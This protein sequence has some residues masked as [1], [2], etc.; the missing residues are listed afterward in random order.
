MRLGRFLAAAG[1]AMLLLLGQ[2]AGAGTTT[3]QGG[4]GEFRHVI[5]INADD[6]SEHALS[7]VPTPNIDALARQGTKV[8]NM[9]TTAGVCAPSRA[10]KE[11]GRYQERYGIFK[12]PPE[13]AAADG[14]KG[15]GIPAS[16]VTVAEAMGKAGVYTGKIG[17]WHLG[18]E[19]AQRPNAQGYDEFIGFLGGGHG[20]AP[21]T[22]PLLRDNK[23][24]QFG[25]NLTDFFAGEAASFITRNASKRFYL[26][27]DPNAP[28]EPLSATPQQ[29]GKCTKFDDQD[30]RLFCG[31]LVG[32]DNMV[33]EVMG[34]V[35]RAGI[36]D[37]TMV[38]FTADNGCA[39]LGYCDSGVFR[40]GKGKPWEGG[41]RV[42]GIFWAPGVIPAGKVYTKSPISHLDLMS[43]S[44]AAVGAPIPGNLDGENVLPWLISNSAGPA[45]D[46]FFAT[47]P[48]RGSIRRGDWKLYFEGGIKLYNLEKDPD[49]SNDVAGQNPDIVK[50]MANTLDQW[51]NE[52]PKPA[53]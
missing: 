21:G 34:A 42:P 29:M 33:G 19:A 5:V 38:V 3:K 31:M 49:E 26:A 36:E 41:V 11:T 32:L 20:Y 6:L 1:A 4:T 52:M 9:Y 16:A 51:F 23:P 24:V 30:D 8:S 28:H 15:D 40:M 50:P 45:R 37:D 12:N 44:L 27:L 43:T 13:G 25:E 17:K 39:Q 48:G 14:F 53:Y 2:G 7:Q 46:L 35:K 10:G 47:I 18:D 22:G